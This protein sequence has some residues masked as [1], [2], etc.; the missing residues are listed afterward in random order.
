MSNT[1][2]LINQTVQKDFGAYHPINKMKD[3]IMEFINNLMVL[4]L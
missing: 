3:I 1:K 2:K 4:K